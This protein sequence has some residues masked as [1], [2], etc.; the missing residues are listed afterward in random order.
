MKE[1]HGTKMEDNSRKMKTIMKGANSMQFILPDLQLRSKSELSQYREKWIR[2]AEDCLYGH[3]PKNTSI[4]STC[5]NKEI[6]WGGSGTKETI[7]INYGTKPEHAFD[8]KVYAPAL[9]G[10]HPCITWNQFS[11]NEWDECPYE[12]T[13]SKKGYIIAVFEREKIW[14]DKLG[15]KRPVCEAYPEYDWGAIRAWAWAQSL[16]LDYLLTR[17]DTD[18]S[19]LI[20]TGFSRGGKTALACGIFDERY[21]ITV[22]VCSGA[23]G[24]GCFRYLGDKD[25]FC[26]DVT[27]VESLGRIGSVFPFWWTDEFSRWWPKPD[28]TQMGL[29]GSFPIDSHILKTLIAPR[30]LF[31][32]EGIDDAWSNPRGTELTREAAQ[33]AFDLYGGNN[34]IH[35]RDGGH[36]F[37]REDWQSLTD[38]CDH[39]FIDIQ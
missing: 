10:K 13:V 29:E 5:I 32:I 36:A 4:Q 24:C 15:G 28:P 39:V 22:P 3:A 1:E 35:Y 26:Q 31:S 16:I 17:D 27:K 2:M 6:L 33:P 30:Y 8:V 14:E 9:T 23:G 37:T 25:G 21:T 34:D 7:R 20:C 12:E 19:K 11:D 18:P 38:Y